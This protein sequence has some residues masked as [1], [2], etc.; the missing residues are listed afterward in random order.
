MPITGDPASAPSWSADGTHLTYVTWSEVDAGAVWTIAA[1]GSAPAVKVSDLPAFYTQPAFT[2]DGQSIL[3]VRSP[4]A[5]RQQ[6]S[7]EWGTV[8][9]GELVA[10]PLE[11]AAASG[12]VR[13]VASG[14]FGQ[15][16]HFVRGQDGTA[17]LLGAD[18]L[19]AV[20][21]G[22]GTIR[23]V[24]TVTAPGYYF[25]EQPANA[26]DMRISPDGRWIA[27]QTSEQLYLLPVPAD[28]EVPVDVGT[29]TTP[30]ARRITDMGADFFEW[31]ADGSLV[32][33]VG[34]WLQRITDTGAA[35][36]R[37]HIELIAELPRARPA[38]SLLLRG[39]R[40]LTM[41][42]GDRTIENA[43][44]LITGDRIAAIGPRG[45]LNV[46]PG[47]P[48]RDLGGRTVMPGFIDDHDHIGSIR[49]TVLS[50]EEWG[51][52]ARLAF[53]VTTSFDPSTLGVDQIAY[54]DMIDAG[55]MLGPRLR[56]T[57]PALFSKEP[58]GSLD[59][60]RAVLRRYRDAWGLHNIKQYRG[61]SRKVRQWIAIAARELQLQPTTEGSLNPKLILPQ[62]LDGYAGNEHSLPLSPLQEDVIGLNRRMRTSY[63]ATLLVN[64]S[65][66]SARDWFV[67]AN[68]PARDEK[69]RRF[70]PPMA[71]MHKLGHRDWASQDASRLPSLAAD[72]R[73]LVDG[74]ALVGMGSHGDE[75][76]IG[77]HYELAAHV[78]GGMTPLQVLHAATAG[79]A[80]TLG[81]LDDLGTLE[82][83]KFADIVVFDR[84]PL[85]DIR[86]TSSL[87]LVMR[88]GQLFDAA[89]LDEVWP[90]PRKL[91]PPWFARNA[92]AQWLP[93]QP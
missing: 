59:D 66:P 27:A 29:R 45:S 62:T 75:P 70:W 33:S 37:T 48:E 44:I 69:V 26:D 28:P 73:S 18:G 35:V 24:A 21:L 22:S 72:V 78:M 58:F 93:T 89:T 23:K 81:R 6:T 83:G 87:S 43:D 52:R 36:P 63:V 12:P 17:Y 19:V 53:G 32:W 84:D 16:P 67:A 68:D 10:I 54:Q 49:R 74:G 82:V 90:V 92:N 11:G 61:E 31:G 9:A 47:T 20:D 13:V 40:A 85:A 14:R 25:T 2:P 38:G 86:N 34:N 39:A 79:A 56:S 42:Q 77:Y 88:G 57:G 71:V 80:E 65:G 5:A 60:V 15:R 55:L 8:R 7:F 64:T 46:P 1:N 41:A 51:L 76:G 4:A 30:G 91:P 50:Y 3:T